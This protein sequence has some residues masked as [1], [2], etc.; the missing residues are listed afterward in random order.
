MAAPVPAAS[1]ES[2]AARALVVCAASGA[3]LGLLFPPSPVPVGGVAALAAAATAVAVLVRVID[4]PGHDAAWRAAC[5]AVFGA[6][7]GAAA[8]RSMFPTGVAVWMAVVP[9]V[10]ASWALWAAAWRPGQGVARSLLSVLALSGA[11]RLRAEALLGVSWMGLWVLFVGDRWAADLARVASREAVAAVALLCGLAAAGAVRGA[12]AHSA[13]YLAAAAVLGAVPLAVPAPAFSARVL[14]AVRL[15]VPQVA[16]WHPRGAGETVLQLV[17]ATDWAARRGAQLV[18]WPENAVTADPVAVPEVAAWIRRAARDT[19]VVVHAVAGRPAFRSMVTRPDREYSMPRPAVAS[20]VVERGGK[21]V[22]GGW[23]SIGF[24]FGELG[25]LRGPAVRA[26]DVAGVGRVGSTMCLEPLATRTLFGLW[27]LGVQ[28]LVV[29]ASFVRASPHVSDAYLA[30][31]RVAAQELGVP[32]VV[33]VL[34][35]PAVV[36]GPVGEVVSGAVRGPLGAAVGAVP[37]PVATSPGAAAGAVAG[38]VG[39]AVLAVLLVPARGTRLA[40][41][42]ALPLRYPW[43]L[44][45]VPWSVLVL[46]ALMVYAALG[47]SVPVVPF[48]WLAWA[49]VMGGTGW[50]W[51]GPMWDS[52]SRGSGPV[53]AAAC[54]LF[55][56][57]VLTALASPE[58]A[59]FALLMWPW[60]AAARAA[61]VRGLHAAAACAATGLAGS[62]LGWH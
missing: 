58:E 23:K 13:C 34:S 45:A 37:V 50:I 19:S 2:S 61:G 59:G 26:A 7:L 29:G 4:D 32:A 35:G 18:V 62:A 1:G 41:W 36:V 5:G 15:D 21:V 8:S 6:S 20:L 51:L 57:P 11:E 47:G 27:R 22:G 49:L 55:V 43:L 44:W 28:V 30:H 56:L 53:G 3:V 33:S 48:R 46:T 52:I 24:P 38:W 31:V 12:W 16:L 17:G 54:A 10:A 40:R 14:A 42:G 60:L 25:V 9:A 39:V